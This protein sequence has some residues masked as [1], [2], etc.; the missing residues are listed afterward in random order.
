MKFVIFAKIPISEILILFCKYTFCVVR[1]SAIV[2]GEMTLFENLCQ[3]LCNVC[4]LLAFSHVPGSR[5]E[6]HILKQEGQLQR[7]PGTVWAAAS[8]SPA[9]PSSTFMFW[10]RTCL[11]QAQAIPDRENHEKKKN[12]YKISLPCPTPEDREKLPINTKQFG[13]VF[14]TYG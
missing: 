14:F 6:C 8:Q 5:A 1:C 3:R 12:F 10:D 2:L 7:P 4:L 11:L 9:A 13:G